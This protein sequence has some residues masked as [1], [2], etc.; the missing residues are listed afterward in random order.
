[1]YEIME[2]FD[3]MAEAMV[4]DVAIPVVDEDVVFMLSMW[5]YLWG[6]LVIVVTDN[7]I[8]SVVLAIAVVDDAVVEVVFEVVIVVL[9]TVAVLLWLLLL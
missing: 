8:P 2:V 9:V 5:M 3:V 1:M 4:L 6:L 7:V